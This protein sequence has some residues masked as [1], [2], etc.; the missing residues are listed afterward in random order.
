MSP[1]NR[2]LP[3]APIELRRRQPLPALLGRV[4]RIAVFRALM[5]GDMLCA[6]PALRAL[7]RGF[8]DAEITLVGLP[9]AR[10]LVQRLSCVDRCIDFPGHPAL[11]EVPCDVR[12][13]PDFLAQVQAQRFDLALQMHGSGELANPLL[14]TFGAETT[15]GFCGPGAWRPE[16]DAALYAP[17]PEQGHEIE[18]LLTLTDW[19]GLP[20]QGTQMEFPVGAADRD[21]LAQLWPGARAPRPYVCVHA[22]AQLPSRRWPFER[23]AQV[24][25]RLAAQ[26]RTVVLTGGAPESELARALES[27]MGTPPVNLVGRTS[28]WTLGALIEGCEAVVCNDTGLSHVAAALR[29]PS[30]VVSSGADVARWAPLDHDRHTVLWQDMPCRPCTHAVCP[31]PHGCAEAVG[32]DAVMRALQDLP[33][34]GTPLPLHGAGRMPA[35]M[36]AFGAEL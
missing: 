26:G 3:I 32:V 28:L 4:Q 21:E 10:Q 36:M 27:R 24:A 33:R 11:P 17:W 2:S 31:L 23:F 14:A 1:P 20:R 15:A 13:L 30:V 22:G 25:D 16:A 18:R 34:Q 12:Q 35:G 6:V 7:R 29:R 19:L 8:P 9:W 5:L